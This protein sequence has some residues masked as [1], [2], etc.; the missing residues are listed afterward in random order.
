M[1]FAVR[2]R[3]RGGSDG[4]KGAGDGRAQGVLCFVASAV[5]TCGASHSREERF[6]PQRENGSH[7]RALSVFA[8]D[9]H[10]VGEQNCEF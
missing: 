1:N 4:K 7:V 8:G 9:R 6:Q 3:R 10:V 2:R 5:V